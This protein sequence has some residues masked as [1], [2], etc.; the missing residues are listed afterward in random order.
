[1]E[2]CSIKGC[3]RAVNARGLCGSHYLRWRKHGDPLKGGLLPSRKGSPCSIKG[4]KSGATSRGWCGLHY[5]RWKT[6]GDPLGVKEWTRNGAPSISSDGP[7]LIERC[8]EPRHS[9][10]YCKDHYYRLR[11]YGDPKATRRA[12][13][14]GEGT[15][16]NGY[17]FTTVR[18]NGTQRQ[19]GTHRLVMQQKL[20]RELR[21]NENV[22]H[23]NGERADNRPE[24]L[25]LWVKSQPCG[26]RPVD[27]VAWAR[28]II[29]LYG[30]EIDA[31]T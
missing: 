3:G 13:R 19:I 26:Q 12:R 16:N 7:C 24:N 23:I 28:D 20:G 18:V 14:K 17:H 31:Q 30:A 25:E 10:G 21:P 9:R 4:C 22:H 5:Q 1:M 15:T 11:R 8:R 29:A 27:L 2:T 6:T